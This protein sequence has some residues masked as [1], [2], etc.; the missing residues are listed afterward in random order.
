MSD[1][2]LPPHITLS[3]LPQPLTPPV[4]LIKTEEDVERWHRSKG[5]RDYCLFVQ[6]LNEAVVGH[7]L[8]SE[9]RGSVDSSKVQLRRVVYA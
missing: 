4:P 9:G 1:V 6:R 8:P 3:S 7:G 5:Y 2:P